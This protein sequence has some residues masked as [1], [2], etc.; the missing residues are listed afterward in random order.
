MILGAGERRVGIGLRLVPLGV[1]HL[2]L[3]IWLRVVLLLGL[4]AIAAAAKVAWISGPWSQAIWPILASM[5][6]FRLIVYITT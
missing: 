3:S 4:G 5:F 6:M 1:C 2:P